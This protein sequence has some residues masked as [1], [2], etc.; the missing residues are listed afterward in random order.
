MAVTGARWGLE[1]GEAVLRLRALL[2][3]G[4]LDDYLDFHKAQERARNHLS[5]YED[6][7]VPTLELPGRRKPRLR[8]VP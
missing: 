8:M 3:T 2:L 7:E 6:G 5:R 1:G 4:D